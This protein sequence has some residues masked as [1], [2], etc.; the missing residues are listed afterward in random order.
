MQAMAEVFEW[1]NR[2][3]GVKG[4]EQL[5]FHPVFIAL[6]V[7]LVVFGFI[8]GW[9]A[10]YLPVFTILGGAVIFHYFYPEDASRLDELIK[11][12]AVTGALAMVVIYFGF[13]RE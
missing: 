11:F 12:L 13:I 10:L 7:I 4:P 6:C 2:L 9:K 8:K 1:V 5:I 3:L